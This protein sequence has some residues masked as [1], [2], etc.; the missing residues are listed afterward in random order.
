MRLEGD[1]PSPMERRASPPGWT[2]RGSVD[3]PGWRKVVGPG[4]TPVNSPP[5]HWRD[6]ARVENT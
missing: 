5:V 2:L 6:S 3:I 1:I 4:G